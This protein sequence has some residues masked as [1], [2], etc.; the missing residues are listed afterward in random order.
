M[1]SAVVRRPGEGLREVLQVLVQ[2]GRSPILLLPERQERSLVG[3]RLAL[4]LLPLVLARCRRDARRAILARARDEAEE[5]LPAF[6]DPVPQNLR[7][8]QA[9]RI[10]RERSRVRRVGNV[11]LRRM[12]GA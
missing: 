12:P 10:L 7:L 4:V 9:A 11:L 1:P 5:A 2:D 8:V 6:E 3:A